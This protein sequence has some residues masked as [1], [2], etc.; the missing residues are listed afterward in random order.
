M[1]TVEV[2]GLMQRAMSVALIL[3]GPFLLVGLVVGVVVGLLQA[4]TQ[5]NEA[6]LSFI[7]KLLAVGLVLLLAGQWMLQKLMAFTAEILGGLSRM[8]G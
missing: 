1:T 7:P 3:V 4:M 8:T 5:I 6:T 2:V